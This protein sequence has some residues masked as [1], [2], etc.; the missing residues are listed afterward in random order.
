MSNRDAQ[1]TSNSC[2][3][4]HSTISLCWR[5]PVHEVWWRIPYSWQKF[6]RE[7]LRYSPLLSD[8]RTRIW[9]WY[10]VTTILY[11]SWNTEHTSSL[12]ESRDTQVIRVYS[13][14]NVIKYQAPNRLGIRAGPHT[15]EWI[16]INKIKFLL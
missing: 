1:T 11:K 12:C 5:V 15:S 14:I 2:R 8:Y 6:L 9:H 13:S 16:V 3:F 4:F 10:C 7:E